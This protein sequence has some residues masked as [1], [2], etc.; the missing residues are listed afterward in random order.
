MAGVA[1]VPHGLCESGPRG[2]E[3]GL[4]HD[5]DDAQSETCNIAILTTFIEVLKPA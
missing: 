1:D 3:Q 5:D 2:L 4:E